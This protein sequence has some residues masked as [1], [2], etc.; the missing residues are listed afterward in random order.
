MILKLY[1]SKNENVFISLIY[2]FK[3]KT[4]NILTIKILVINNHL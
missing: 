4:L 3:D 2:D 1:D